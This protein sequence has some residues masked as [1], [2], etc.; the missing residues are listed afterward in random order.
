MYKLIKKLITYTTCT[1]YTGFITMPLLWLVIMSLKTNRE[2]TSKPYSLPSK[3]LF[4]NYFEVW[5]D[6]GF[7]IYFKNSVLIVSTSILFIVIFGSMASY[8]FAKIKFK[9]SEILYILMFSSIMIPLQVII[10]PIFQLFSQ[11]SIAGTRFSLVLIYITT[12]LPLSIYILRSFY[13]QIPNSL[14]ESA[15]IDGASEWIIFWKIMFP[16]SRPAVSTVIILHFIFIWNEFLLSNIFI[17]E[18]NL[19]TVPLGLMQYYGEYFLDFAHL[20]A[21]A[22]LSA[23]PILI[24]YA[25]FS[26]QFVKGMT[27]GALKE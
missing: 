26:E 6:G 12:Q 16:I 19:R 15:K 4:S 14:S 10:I 25:I 8:V 1:I 27:A 17:R 11:Y 18:T 20:S 7:N 22:L 3:W 13:E 5:S 24:L 23:L 2:I 9:G 21:A